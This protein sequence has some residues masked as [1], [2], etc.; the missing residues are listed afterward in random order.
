MKTGIKW[1]TLL[2][3]SG[4]LISGCSSEAK[5]ERRLKHE[6]AS[7]VRNDSLFMGLYFGMPEKDFYTQ[8]WKL[9]KKG[10]IRQ[11]DSNTTV[12]YEM[13]GEL[14]YPANMEFYPKFKQ[15]LISELPVEFVYR[16]WAPWNKKL[17][18]DKLELDVLRWYEKVYGKGF[19]EVRHPVRGSAFVKIDGNRRIT[20]FKQDELHVWAYFTDLLIKKDWIDSSTNTGIPPVDTTKAPKN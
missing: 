5:Y 9:N 3:I 20:I 17:S 12:L 7:G 4:F 15:G 18:S 1:V 2:L 8:C 19:I 6:L 13:K 10:L 14:Q 11:G 16:G